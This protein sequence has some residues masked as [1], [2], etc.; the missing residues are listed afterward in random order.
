[1]SLNGIEN[2]RP[3]AKVKMSFY[4]VILINPIN[5]DRVILDGVTAEVE[6]RNDFIDQKD[7][8]GIKKP[9]P[10]VSGSYLD[11]VLEMAT[12]TDI[13]TIEELKKTILH[14]K[15]FLYFADV[16]PNLLTGHIKSITQDSQK[17]TIRFKGNSTD[18]TYN[19][20]LIEVATQL[21]KA[22]KL[23]IDKEGNT[24]PELANPNAG[25]PVYKKKVSFREDHEDIK[26]RKD[27]ITILKRKLTF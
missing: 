2:L 21:N 11:I 3:K 9:T 18:K 7:M 13:E 6:I 20:Y 19:E 15:L 1:M 12:P 23:E 22:K 5:L 26:K 24:E 16:H 4:N 27:G 17:M 8:F 14:D 10:V 25:Q